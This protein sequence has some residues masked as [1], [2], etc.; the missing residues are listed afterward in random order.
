VASPN[1]NAGS[2]VGTGEDGNPD[3]GSGLAAGDANGVADAAALD[4]AS[5]GRIPVADGPTWVIP[6]TPPPTWAAGVIS[7]KLA[8]EIT[9]IAPRISPRRPHSEATACR[10]DRQERRASDPESIA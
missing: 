2:S 4:D 3:A 6:S 5:A 1:W 10:I 8:R 7:R 9:T